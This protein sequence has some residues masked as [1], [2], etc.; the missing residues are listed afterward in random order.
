MDDKDPK[1]IET[2][3][4][5]DFF[6]SMLIRDVSLKDVI[7]DL[8]DNCVDGAR[9]KT[10][11]DDYNGYN[12]DIVF[13]K[14]GFSISDNCGGIE[15]EIAR[16]YA[17][18]IG[19]AK[20]FPG[21]PGSVGQFGIGMKRA[22]FK[23]GKY[24]TISSA[25]PKSYWELDVDVD[26]W[27]SREGWEFQFKEF[28]ESSEPKQMLGTHIHVTKLNPDVVTDFTD[29]KFVNELKAELELENLYPISKGL[30]ITLNSIQLGK[31]NLELSTS[32]TIKP[33]YYEYTSENNV[34][35]KVITGIGEPSL[36]DGG[37]YLFCNGRLVL[38]PEQTP[39]TGWTGGRLGDG[40]PKYHGQFNRFRGY[41]F[42]EADDAGLL[43]W[44]TTKNGVD[45]D[46]ALFKKIRAR[47]IEM[48]KPVI[49]FLNKMKD[50]REGDPSPSDLFYQNEVDKTSKVNIAEI[51]S[52]AGAIAA[53]TA[54][55]FTH[56]APAIR[57]ERVNTIT[58]SYKKPKEEVDKVKR[59]L[60]TKSNKEVGER[61]F[62]YFL[63]MEA[64]N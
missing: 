32:D 1:R 6:I 24:F 52:S 34:H 20:G 25:A 40:G 27:S 61:T 28:E 53:Y 56:P 64:D 44:N 57:A 41:V 13:D 11:N 15:V 33:A 14:N 54:K 3:P 4:T 63:D 48:M 55:V 7:G 47:M 8:V 42:F 19:R 36:E 38:G 62:D 17:F 5:K 23:I 21:V 58:I 46:S 16:H 10:I 49:T 9:S 37:W 26:D 22:L 51:A 35:V 39:I 31:R 50:E 45:L 29:R 30:N 59:I 43:P 2:E 18:R 12:I 60:E